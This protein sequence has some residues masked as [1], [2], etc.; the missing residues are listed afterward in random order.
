MGTFVEAHGDQPRVFTLQPVAVTGTRLVVLAGSYE[1]LGRPA[2][3]Q[4]AQ[5]TLFVDSS[6]TIFAAN[7]PTLSTALASGQTVADVSTSERLYGAPNVPIEQ[8]VAFYEAGVLRET[9]YV[10]D[11]V[12]GTQV[13]LR[14]PAPSATTLPGAGAVEVRWT[15]PWEEWK[16]QRGRAGTT[17]EEI[18]R[19]T[20]LTRVFGLDELASRNALKYP[21]L[22][23]LD[24]FPPDYSYYDTVASH[25]VSPISWTEP[26]NFG[27]FLRT[28]VVVPAG[29]L[30][31]GFVNV[32]PKVGTI[33]VSYS[34]RRV[35]DAN[36]TVIG[37]ASQ[38]EWRG[39]GTLQAN[40]L[41]NFT[42]VPVNTLDYTYDAGE[43]AVKLNTG[44]VFAV[45]FAVSRA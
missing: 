27:E 16:T 31:L 15:R 43:R 29:S 11:V 10:T 26:M 17:P 24:E 7:Y 30:L 41:V 39:T 45:Q 37:R 28:T 33:D 38:T 3:L 8:E 34:V 25:A 5:E 22:I 23:M 13:H 12:S 32:G 2:Y 18:P 19:N 4:V 44:G 36:G 6:A 40:G 20:Q 9:A 35:A 1:Q 42:T 14:R 21:P